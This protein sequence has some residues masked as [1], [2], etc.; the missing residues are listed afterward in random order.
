MTDRNQA[1]I[2]L[3]EHLKELKLDYLREFRFCP[4]RKWQADFA[5]GVA[6]WEHKGTVLVEIEGGVWTEGRHTRGSGFIKDIEK[7]NHAAIL[8]YRLLRFS[9]QHVLEG[10][11]REFLKRW[12]C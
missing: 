12:L 2:L 7:Y 10:Q 1:T 6:P 5:I 3:E 4:G 8:G 9:T 11:A